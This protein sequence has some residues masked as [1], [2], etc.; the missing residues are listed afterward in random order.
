MLLRTLEIA[1]KPVGVSGR[2]RASSVSVV[3]ENVR[4]E[5][6]G[7]IGLICT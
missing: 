4:V 7:L 5:Q 6:S 1:S 3:C 2:V